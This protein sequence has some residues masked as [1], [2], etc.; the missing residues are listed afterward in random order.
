MTSY[1][2][3]A[4][5]GIRRTPACGGRWWP[6]VRHLFHAIA[7][8]PVGAASM[9]RMLRCCATQMITFRVVVLPE[10]GSPVRM[11]TLLVNAIR[12]AIFCFS[13]RVILRFCSARLMAKSKWIGSIWRA[14]LPL[15]KP[16]Q[17]RCQLLLRPEHPAK[18]DDGDLPQVGA[19]GILDYD[20][21]ALR[22]ILVEKQVFERRV[23]ALRPQADFIFSLLNED[24]AVKKHMPLGRRLLQQVQHDCLGAL[25]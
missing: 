6:R 23:G 25:G 4:A 17:L 11:D 21:A 9:K 18:V 22:R 14:G 8:R 12:T 5:S 19:I 24:A 2:G 20:R 1:A 13:L 10:P 15:M 7:A 16:P 3:V